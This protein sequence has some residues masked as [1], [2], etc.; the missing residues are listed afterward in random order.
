[1]T[2]SFNNYI[3]F[4]GDLR[5]GHL[6]EFHG[7][8]LDFYSDTSLSTTSILSKLIMSHVLASETLL[9]VRRLHLL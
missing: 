6:T 1:M 2:K 3:Y 7:T 9:P 4:V 5:N 8:K